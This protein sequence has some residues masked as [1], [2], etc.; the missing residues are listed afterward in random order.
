[1]KNAKIWTI[2]AF[3]AIGGWMIFSS[4]SYF[5]SQ[6]YLV[7]TY[8]RELDSLS[9]AIQN[10]RIDREEARK[11]WEERD[12]AFSGRINDHK[13]RVELLRLCIDAESIK[14]REEKK[15]SYTAIS[16]VHA[17]EAI[18]TD[19]DEA[20]VT[21]T[22][23]SEEE[24]TKFWATYIVAIRE[25]KK[26]EG[27]NPK[28]Y[29]DYKQYTSGWGTKAKNKWEILSEAEADK[30]LIEYVTPLVREVIEDFPELHSDW[31]WALVSFRYNCPAWY[32]AVKKNWLD[33]HRLWCKKAGGK[34]IKWLVAR[35]NA[36]ASLI[37]NKK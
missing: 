35:R 20:I 34:I 37:F 10:L 28:P 31:Q 22:N 2:L 13:A 3:V 8:S 21:I 29:W 19:T 18:V 16:S 33:H 14:C 24:N 15:Q 4:I 1:M 5:S 27:F 32:W 26:W 11:I 12:S 25:I 30:R 7:S 23:A 36:E 6:S 17:G 9:G